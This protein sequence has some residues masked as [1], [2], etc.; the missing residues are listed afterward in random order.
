[1]RRYSTFLAA[2]ADIAGDAIFSI[3]AWPATVIAD[4][5]FTFTAADKAYIEAAQA[6][7][8]AGAYHQVTMTDLTEG[9]IYTLHDAEGSLLG[10]W[11]ACDE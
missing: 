8:G 9:A 10:V 6:A 7:G 1:M 5:S 4:Y 11:G 2:V 3:D